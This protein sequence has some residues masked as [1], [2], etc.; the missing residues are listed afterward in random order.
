MPEI[1]PRRLLLALGVGAMGMLLLLAYLIWSGHR[2]AIRSTEATTR[3]Y[4]AVFEARLDA[5]LRHTNAVLQTLAHQIP[6]AAL[7]QQAVPLYARALDAALDL[8]IANFAELAG[9]RITDASGNILYTSDSANTPRAQVADRSYFRAVRDNPRLNL[10]FSEVITARTTGRQSVAVA[11]ALRD[12]QGAFRGTVY[13]LLELEHFLKLMKS[14]DLGANGAVV[15]R[16][17]DDFTRV[18]RW[19]A[20][21]D[22]PNTALP[23]NSPARAVLAGGT[24]TATTELIAPVDGIKRIY[25]YH[26]L[27]SYPF[28][29]GVGIGSDDALAGWRTRSLV[30]GL[31]T[32]LLLGLLISLLLRLERAHAAHAQLAAIE[33]PRTMPSSAAI[34]KARY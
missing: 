33:A 5:T 10:A 7:D 24:R 19:P 26:A 20:D 9:I 2:E 34:P 11:K 4:A 6:R 25:S 29:I 8:E 18:L 17:S 1:S 3:G 23:Q 12:E 30:A 32:L 14:L 16:R 22:P 27:P 21:K 31:F 13:V 28:Y 15:I